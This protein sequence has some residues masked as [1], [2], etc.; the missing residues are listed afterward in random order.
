MCSIRAHAHQS[1]LGCGEPNVR[2]SSRTVCPSVALYTSP[3]AVR[4][5]GGSSGRQRGSCLLTYSTN[6]QRA[7]ARSVVFHSFLST[8]PYSDRKALHSNN[9]R[10]LDEMVL[11]DYMD[12]CVDQD[13]AVFI[14]GFA[15]IDRRIAVLNISQDQCPWTHV[16]SRVRVRPCHTHRHLRLDL[17]HRGVSKHCRIVQSY[18][19]M[20]YWVAFTEENNLLGN[21]E[22][23]NIHSHIYVFNSLFLLCPSFLF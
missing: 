6:S 11:T 15:L 7:D 1:T 9:Q 18:Q 12:V 5:W 20:S 16:P 8:N 3:S 19:N 4:I 17:N 13:I 21:Y 10:A 22:F 23:M 14:G 2:H